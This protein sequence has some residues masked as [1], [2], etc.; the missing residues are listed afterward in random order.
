M[1]YEG[2]VYRPPSEARSFILQV[3]IGCSH[4]RCT[5][6]TMYK[7]K[8]FRIRK[9]EEIKRDIKEV[10]SQYG[11]IV[12]RIF[13]AD[14]DALVLSNAKLLEILTNLKAGFPNAER[15]TSYGTPDDVLRKT[16]AELLELKAAGLDMIYMG[17]ESGDEEVLRKID[18]G[19][20]VQ[21][22]IEA[23]IR[24]KQ[25]GILTSV[26]L[27]SGLGGRERLSEHAIHSA[28]AI[29]KMNPD[30][31]GFLTLMVEEPAE[32]VEEIR[33]GRMELL[34]PPEIVD[35]MELFLSHV[36]SPGT[37]FRAN[38]ASNYIMLKGM[39][40]L[41]IPEMLEYLNRVRINQG[42]RKEGWRSL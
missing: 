22:T 16:D 15:I 36:S 11:S 30:F 29:T 37:V 10:S 1:E 2:M 3:T 39:L 32:I 9:M 20:T 12:R 8:Q 34:T 24:L 21:D 26:T 28:E 13:L 31:V 40:D 41:D 38:H 5:F 18:K 6:C 19:V 17:L 7:D 23:G 14:G 42:F 33:S 25:A 35:E 4:N 27:I